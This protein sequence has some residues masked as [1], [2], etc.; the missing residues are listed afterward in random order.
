T[1]HESKPDVFDTLNVEHWEQRLIREAL[2][3][4]RGNIPESAEL[5]GISRATLYRKLEIYNIDKDSFQ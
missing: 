2:K 3:R 5:L 4:T 1:L